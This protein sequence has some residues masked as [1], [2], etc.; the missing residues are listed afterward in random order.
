[1]NESKK[2]KI[3]LIT[4]FT[5]S[6]AIPI[7]VFYKYNSKDSSKNNVVDVKKNKN[8]KNEEIIKN[9][10]FLDEF[11]IFQTPLLK[12]R[13]PGESINY[14]N[15]KEFFPIKGRDL[16][17]Y[18]WIKVK[19][20][21]KDDS[22]LIFISD[23]EEENDNFG[24]AVALTRT[25]DGIHPQVYWKDKLTKKNQLNPNYWLDFPAIAD[26]SD[27]WVVYILSFR[28]GH[29]L[30][31]NLGVAITEDKVNSKLIGGYD[32]GVKDLNKT[33]IS[34]QE[35]NEDKTTIPK[36]NTPE[37]CQKHMSALECGVKIEE[38]FF[39]KDAVLKSSL[40]FGA[41]SNS[42]YVAEIG[43]HGVLQLTEGEYDFK[44]IIKT[45]TN[46]LVCED[47]QIKL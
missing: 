19:R 14:Q 17:V 16:F 31:L 28:H 37:N 27:I 6:F 29:I 3:L 40:V 20:Y 25:Q 2:L 44:T 22:R 21:P 46:L 33:D 36:K 13:K 26:Y 1:M 12:V 10:Q 39:T 38:R 11:S 9:N 32:I 8:Q 45:I 34:L 18:T 35:N 15:K 23:L 24:Y 43:K 7:A 30:G 47:R 41:P 42:N 5:V 4:I